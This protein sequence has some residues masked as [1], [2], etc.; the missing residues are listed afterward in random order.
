MTSKKLRERRVIEAV[1]TLW[2]MFPHGEILSGEAP[3]F[4]VSSSENSVFGFEILTYY[5]PKRSRTGIPKEQESLRWR[6][7]RNVEM[8]LQEHSA[9]PIN[10][11]LHFNQHHLLTKKSVSALTRDIVGIVLAHS[12]GMKLDSS[13]RISRMDE[14]LPEQ[15]RSIRISRPAV[16]T[17]SSCSPPGATGVPT[18]DPTEIQDLIDKKNAKICRYLQKCDDVAL[19]IEIHGF[20]LSSVAELDDS[21]FSHPFHFDF[22]NVFILS[23]GTQLIELTK[24]RENR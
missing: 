23:D 2:T 7:S 6:V 11:A 8:G 15:I 13:I 21:V 17:R 24:G 14:S 9:N 19:V 18:L 20:Q 16:L 12:S 3:D 22:S 5:R 10:V 4:T 1:R